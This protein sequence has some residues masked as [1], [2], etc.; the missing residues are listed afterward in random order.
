MREEKL[1]Y[2]VDILFMGR[3]FE[4]NLNTSDRNPF[5]HYKYYQLHPDGNF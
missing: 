5:F 4:G 2:E 1:L 3:S